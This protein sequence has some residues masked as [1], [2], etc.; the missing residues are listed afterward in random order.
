MDFSMISSVKDISSGQYGVYSTCA[1]PV[2]QL[3]L[4]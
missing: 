3:R 2:A 4:K 1:L